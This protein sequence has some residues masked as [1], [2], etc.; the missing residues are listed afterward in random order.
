MNKPQLFGADY[1]VYVR[2]C[3]LSLHE[4]GIDYELIPIDIFSL[5][6]ASATYLERQPFGKIPSFEH[7]SFRL[8]ETGAIT[9]YIDEA[10]DGP[11]LQPTGTKERAR[12]NQI[13]SIADGYIYPQL[14]WGMYV[15]LVSKVARDEPT[16]E[17]RV[18]AARAKAP[19]YLDVLANFLGKTPWLASDHITLADL[20]LAPMLDYFLQ[21]PEGSGMLSKRPNLEE[22]WN[23]MRRRESMRLSR[24]PA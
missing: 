18:A 7:D 17:A 21:V 15:E 3:R 16:D 6:D 23:R 20:Y 24:L 19:V 22:W 14:V 12:M 13:I 1:S 2:I 9:R 11:A 8:Y 10:F 4:K 5:G